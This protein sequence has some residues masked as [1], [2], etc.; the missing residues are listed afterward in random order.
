M[1]SILC[2]RDIDVRW[3]PKANAQ[4]V[5]FRCP[6]RESSPKPHK[7]ALFLIQRKEPP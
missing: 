7:S 1:Q 3:M 4:V 2:Q 5:R 6:V